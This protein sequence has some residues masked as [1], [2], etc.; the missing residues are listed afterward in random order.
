M[1]DNHPQRHLYSPW[2]GSACTTFVAMTAFLQEMQKFLTTEKVSHTIVEIF[3]NSLWSWFLHRC[4]YDLLLLTGPLKVYLFQ[5][6]YFVNNLRFALTSMPAVST[7]TISSYRS[8][9]VRLHDFQN[10][11]KRINVLYVLTLR[12]VLMS[13]YVSIRSRWLWI[14]LKPFLLRP[15]NSR[16]HNFVPSVSLWLLW[17]DACLQKLLSTTS[18]SYVCNCHIVMLELFPVSVEC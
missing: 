11:L 12:L 2:P 1:H 6:S 7:C 14:I 5:T 9:P 13:F 8:Y 17:L 4:F 15:P 10:C 18:S 16:K 3:L